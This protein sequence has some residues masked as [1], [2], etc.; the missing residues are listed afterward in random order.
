MSRTVD[1]Y[2]SMVSPWA[3]L[4]HA[5]FMEIAAKHGLIVNWK[6]VQLGA[7]FAE[8]GGLPLGKRAVQRQRYRMVELQRW[9]AK[10]GRPIRFKPAHWPFDPTLA[11]A[12]VVALVAAGEDPAAFIAAGMRATWEDDRD[13]ADRATLAERLTASGFDAAA[14]LVAAESPAVAA[15]GEANRAEAF[16]ADVFGSPGY[17][18]DGE[19]FWG[20]DRLDMLDDALTSG[21]PPF[22]PGF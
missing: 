22:A 10:R 14:I 12:A 9:A 8:T 18:L 13:M 3:Y 11:D 16:A 15:A 17:V 1:V 20:Q 19:V 6:P 5:P 21:R 4:G 7:L 2:F